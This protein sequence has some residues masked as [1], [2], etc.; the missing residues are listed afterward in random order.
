MAQV[1]ENLASK[2]RPWVQSTV[3]FFLKVAGD[4]IIVTKKN[5]LLVPNREKLLEAGK[6]KVVIGFERL[7][8]LT[9]HVGH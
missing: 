3:S 7:Q 5:L 2:D 4:L 9:T 1:I 8:S 6:R